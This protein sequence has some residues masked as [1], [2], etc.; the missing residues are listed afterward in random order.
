MT[1][2]DINHRME[3]LGLDFYM[4]QGPRGHWMLTHAGSLALFLGTDEA[5]AARDC[6]FFLCGLTHAVRHRTRRPDSVMTMLDRLAVLGG[7][8]DEEAVQ[9]P[10]WILR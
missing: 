9:M 5:E 10:G 6:R 2:E 1:A 8:P 3:R 7:M 4:I